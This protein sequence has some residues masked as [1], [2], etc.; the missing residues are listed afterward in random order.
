M[1]NPIKDVLHRFASKSQSAKASLVQQRQVEVEKRAELLAAINGAALAVARAGGQDLT[2]V[3][4][5]NASLAAQDQVIAAYD[6]MIAEEDQAERARQREVAM[7]GAR[8][9]VAAMRQKLGR[10]ERVLKEIM[11]ARRTEVQCYDELQE[12]HSDIEKLSPGYPSWLHS[13]HWEQFH[14][15]KTKSLAARELVCQSY[16]G[17][18]MTQYVGPGNLPGTED[19]TAYLGGD[20]VGEIKDIVEVAREQSAWAI[21]EFEQE[22]GLTGDKPMPAPPEAAPILTLSPAEV[23]PGP[24]VP[25]DPATLDAAAEAT[26]LTVLSA[27]SACPWPEGSPERQEWLDAL[28]DVP[29]P[30]PLDA[31][32]AAEVAKFSEAAA[33]INQPKEE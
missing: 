26:L 4:N 28:N 10:R 1:A 19:L 32:V 16:R 11:G 2:P 23:F 21:R 22:L 17:Q 20:F 15:N 31:A 27:G 3:I 13:P 30:T 5:A 24:I 18:N 12:L 7:K 9:R 6:Q 8:S 14:I 33:A 25:P 29:V